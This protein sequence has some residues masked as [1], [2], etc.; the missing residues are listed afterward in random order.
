MFKT[1]KLKLLVFVNSQWFSLSL[2]SG[3]E[4][5]GRRCLRFEQC[6]A[7]FQSL[8]ILLSL[9]WLLRCLIDN[10]KTDG[11]LWECAI[12]VDHWL[13][14][15]ALRLV[16]S[17]TTVNASIASPVGRNAAMVRA[18]EP[19][20]GTRLGRT[21]LRVLVISEHNCLNQS[22]DQMITHFIRF[23]SAIIGS[24]AKLW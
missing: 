23:V 19:A 15:I 21:S 5:R 11:R 16:F 10:R 2:M 1:T 8:V 14:R 3:M 12:A 18:S 17:V 22:Y 9:R 4:W 13:I 20:F 7:R 24:V 6:L